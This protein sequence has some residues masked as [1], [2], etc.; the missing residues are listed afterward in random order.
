MDAFVSGASVVLPSGSFAA[1]PNSRGLG[2]ESG[3]HDAEGEGSP[4]GPSSA[5]DP[6]VPRRDRE[7]ELAERT[8][9]LISSYESYI[10]GN[11]GDEEARDWDRSGGGGYPAGLEMQ[12]SHQ[13]TGKEYSLGFPALPPA[14]GRVCLVLAALSVAL[15]LL[16]AWAN[17]RSD[18][19]H[20]MAPAM[21]WPEEE[22]PGDAVQ[23]VGVAPPSGQ[24]RPQGQIPE[25]TSTPEFT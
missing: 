11:G 14:F 7:A 19:F 21:E 4:G 16:S 24:E 3:D 2:W 25:F 1:N 17:R 20:E 15:P 6:T 10:S 12:S 18:R 8:S 9:S 5:P 13:W 22:T 23:E